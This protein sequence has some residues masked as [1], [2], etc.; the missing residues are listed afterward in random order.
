MLSLLLP[1]E[2]SSVVSSV[3]PRH[4]ELLE[5]LIPYYAKLSVRCLNLTV[6]EYA[7]KTHLS[8]EQLAGEA[9]VEPDRSQRV[10]LMG[11]ALYY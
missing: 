2:H 9:P 4:Q 5:I 7:N 11:S 10:S 8:L 3:V 1:L 6:H